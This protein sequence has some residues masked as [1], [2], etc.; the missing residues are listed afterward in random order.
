MSISGALAT[1][2]SGLAAQSSA[3]ST[4]SNNLANG[5]TYGYKASKATFVSLLSSGSSST[6]SSGSVASH[7]SYNNT[8]QGILISS[9]DDMDLAIE[10]AGYFGI[11]TD[12]NGTSLLYTRAGDFDIDD[13]GYI[14][15]GDG[16]YYLMGWATDKDGKVISDP[17]T[18][19]LSAINVNNISSSVAPTTKMNIIGNLPAEAAVN[20]TFVTTT[21]I[22]DSLGSSN[23]ATITYTKTAKNTWTAKVETGSGT[24]TSSDITLTFNEDGTLANA[25]PT[26]LT[27]ENWTT[28]AADSSITLNF[29]TPGEKNGLLQYNSGEDEPTLTMAIPQDGL[30]LGNLEDINIDKNGSII[31]SFDNGDSRVIAKIPVA[32]F[33]NANGLSQVTGTVYQSNIESG[34]PSFYVAGTS[35]AGAIAGGMLENSTTDTS[36]EFSD[37]MT[38]Q[39]AYS[40]CAQ[41]MTA[42]NRLYDTLLTAVR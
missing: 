14:V 16:S 26:T 32:T 18:T 27:V 39:Q 19:G 17:S 15:T 9:S 30:P 24:V 34:S 25:T 33:P 42:A 40:A 12:Q 41:V 13:N 11:S 36:T 22:Y 38:A 4:I 10:G 2:V 6:S 21:E 37:M 3:F 29:G 20:D 5:S 31:A 23:D 1:A 28:G 8:D 35:G 7:T